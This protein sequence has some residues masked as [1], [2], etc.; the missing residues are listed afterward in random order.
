MLPAFDIAK[1]LTADRRGSDVTYDI[2]QSTETAESTPGLVHSVKSAFP[3]FELKLAESL[4]CVFAEQHCSGN[5][6]AGMTKSPKLPTFTLM[7]TEVRA[8]CL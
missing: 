7:R 2:V 1:F 5:E 3:H 6:I 4:A 8:E